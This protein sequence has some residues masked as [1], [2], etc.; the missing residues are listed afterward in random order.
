MRVFLTMKKYLLII[1]LAINAH[2]TKPMD[3]I[4]RLKQYIFGNNG[5]KD[6][7]QNLERL[8]NIAAFQDFNVDGREFI[9]ELANG[10]PRPTD[11]LSTKLY[12]RCAKLDEG[13]IKS[14]STKDSEILKF[15]KNM[16]IHED[17][18]QGWHTKELG[19]RKHFLETPLSTGKIGKNGQEI[20]IPIRRDEN[21]PYYQWA[22]TNNPN[23]V[24]DSIM[25]NEAYHNELQFLQTQLHKM[26]LYWNIKPESEKKLQQEN[27]EKTRKLLVQEIESFKKNRI[28]FTHSCLKSADF[29][30]L[31]SARNSYQQNR[32]NELPWHKKI[33]NYK[34]RSTLNQNINALN[35]L[36]HKHQVTREL[37]RQRQ[38][39]HQQQRFYE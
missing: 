4:M 12:L 36:Q 19:G 38:E 3:Y 14:G 30:N 22:S 24:T 5:I 35:D 27:F 1:A 26:D 32:W 33:F 20:I 28:P 6:N 31:Q 37:K 25:E 13:D 17:N 21:S 7:D 10:K 8:P 18:W 23:I 15:A 11:L 9:P 34:E 2:E 16:S 29:E 39:Q